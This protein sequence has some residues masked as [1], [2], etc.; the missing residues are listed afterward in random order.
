MPCGAH[1]GRRPAV[2]EAGVV[3]TTMSITMAPNSYVYVIGPSVSLAE[4]E[5]VAKAVFQDVG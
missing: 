2:R 5:K 3:G 1:R 4:L